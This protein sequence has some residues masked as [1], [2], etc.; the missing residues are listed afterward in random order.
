MKLIKRIIKRVRAS[1]NSE[2]KVLKFT[3]KNIK[4]RKRTTKLD[5]SQ[6]E[7]KTIKRAA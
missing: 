5:L 2:K 7:K 3:A 1:Q 4:T 6:G